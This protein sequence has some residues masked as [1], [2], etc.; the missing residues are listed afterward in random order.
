MRLLAK[1]AFLAEVN[2][3]NLVSEKLHS[4]IVAPILFW[5]LRILFGVLVSDIFRFYPG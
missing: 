5:G 3:V 4:P 2:T 1:T